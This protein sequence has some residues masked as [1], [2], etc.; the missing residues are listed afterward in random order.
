[1]NMQLVVRLIVIM[2]CFYQIPVYSQKIYL[3][4]AGNDNNPGTIDKPFATLT[5]ANEKA[6]EIRKSN[7]V[8]Q[9]IEVIALEGEY[10]MMQ[11]LNLTPFD[12]GTP[13]APLVFKADA[14][15]KAVFRGELS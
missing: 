8:I 12:G 1:M 3:S 13:D 6:R 14:G 15:K 5:A 4:P 7:Q 11:P 9:P 2:I 10:F